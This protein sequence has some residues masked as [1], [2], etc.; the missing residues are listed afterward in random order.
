MSRPKITIIGLGYIGGSIGLALKEA[1]ARTPVEIM[2]HDKDLFIARAAQKKGAVDKI[3]WNLIAAC[4]EA[5]ILVLAIPLGAIHDTFKAVGPYLKAGCVVT[6]T[7]TVKGPVLDWAEEILPD[8]VHFVGGNPIINLTAGGGPYSGLEAA[9]ADLFKGALYCLT[10]SPDAAPEAVDLVAGLVQQLGA[11]PYFLDA[12]EHDGLIAAVE[13]LPAV[14]TAVLLEV[15]TRA[16]TWREMR[17]LA[18]VAYRDSTR[19]TIEDAVAN[20]EV[21]LV[22]R[23]NLVRWIEICQ[24]ELETWKNALKGQDEETLD[25]CFQQ[26]IDARAGWL[27]AARSGDWDMAPPVRP[28]EMPS[29][30]TFFSQLLGFGGLRDRLKKASPREG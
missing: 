7:A 14:L 9:K 21:C 24:D 17:R 23:D 8:T 27:K 26:G 25:Q 15:T 2:G 12:A 5:D 4:E 3:H 18:G 29:S 11:N 19:L 1:T 16:P 22:N 28:V 30:G 20:R 13:H 10:P 6:D